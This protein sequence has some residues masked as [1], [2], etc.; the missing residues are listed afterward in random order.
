MSFSSEYGASPEIRGILTSR[1]ELYIAVHAP[2]GPEITRNEAR[3][4]GSIVSLR[5][6][7]YT[8]RAP[9][10]LAHHSQMHV[11][12][13]APTGPGIGTNAD[14]FVPILVPRPLRDF[15]VSLANIPRLISPRS[16]ALW[17]DLSP[18]LYG[19]S[20][21]QCGSITGPTTNIA[22]CI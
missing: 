6:F 18:G 16:T 22:M 19:Q 10:P 4:G 12:N 11:R 17:W 8:S 2:R 1:L 20:F 3:G 7:T 5:R 15:P 14:L 13:S 21:S 9:L